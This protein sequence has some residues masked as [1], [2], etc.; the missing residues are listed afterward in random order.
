MIAEASM[1]Q[2]VHVVWEDANAPNSI[3]AAPKGRYYKLQYACK[4]KKPRTLT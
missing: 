3:T 4:K 1:W 2:A